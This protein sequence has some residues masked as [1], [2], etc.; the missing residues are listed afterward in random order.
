MQFW[1]DLFLTLPFANMKDLVGSFDLDL[2]V[3]PD[4]TDSVQTASKQKKTAVADKT[5]AKTAK[6]KTTSKTTEA[7]SASVVSFAPAKA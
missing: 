1:I 7:E 6:A 3:S 4:S 5:R 2:T